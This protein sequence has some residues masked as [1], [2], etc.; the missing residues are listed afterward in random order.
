MIMIMIVVSVIITATLWD[1]YG[2]F[3]EKYEI[4]MVKPSTM[5]LVLGYTPMWHY[6]E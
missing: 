6:V 3:V 4:R 5:G 1:N 2:L